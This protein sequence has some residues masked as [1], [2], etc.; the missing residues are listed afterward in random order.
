MDLQINTRGNGV[1]PDCALLGRCP[2][3]TLLKESVDDIN[4]PHNSEM[5][6]VVYSCPDFTPV[7]N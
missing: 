1:C 4:A 6:S 2:I 7:D 3:H 5:E